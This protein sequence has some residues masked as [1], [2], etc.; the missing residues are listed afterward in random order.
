S[1]CSR[2]LLFSFSVLAHLQLLLSSPTRRSS[3]L[4]DSGVLTVLAMVAF[5]V[6]RAFVLQGIGEEV[7]FRGYLMQ[8][9]RRRPVIAVLVAAARSEEHTSELQS[10]FELVCRLLLEKK[11]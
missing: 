7:L 6:L 2:R 10:R 8:S 4:G 9:L 3:D 11:N 1:V 5:L